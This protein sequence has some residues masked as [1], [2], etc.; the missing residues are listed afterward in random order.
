VRLSVCDPSD[1]ELLAS[2]RLGDR[3]AFCALYERFAPEVLALC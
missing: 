2:V 1:A 3:D